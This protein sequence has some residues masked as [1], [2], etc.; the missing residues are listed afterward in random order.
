MNIPVSVLDLPSLSLSLSLSLSCSF[1]STFIPPGNVWISAGEQ[2]RTQ[3][4]SRSVNEQ[5]VNGCLHLIAAGNHFPPHLR[6]SSIF[7]HSAFRARSLRRPRRRRRIT[8]PIHP[9]VSSRITHSSKWDI[10]GYI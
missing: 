5:S 1:F 2:K 9:L 7:P 4:A 6:I 3:S 10:D 8:R